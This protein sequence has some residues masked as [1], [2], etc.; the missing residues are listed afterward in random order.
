LLLFCIIY[1]FAVFLTLEIGSDLEEEFGGVNYFGD[2]QHSMLTLMDV[3]LLVEWPEIIRPIMRDRSF[4]LPF[5]LCFQMV[6]TFG[7]MNILIGVIVDSTTTARQ[8]LEKKNSMNRLLHA[9]D[10]WKEVIHKRGLSRDHIS[11]KSDE[12]KQAALEERKEAIVDIMDTILKEGLIDF[13]K[14]LTAKDIIALLDFDANS[15]IYVEEF[16]TGLERLL[17]GND[18]QL[19]CLM[20]T[21][22]G[23]MRAE[24]KDLINGVQKALTDVSDR[25]KRMEE[26]GLIC[27]VGEKHAAQLIYTRKIGGDE[28]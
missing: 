5:F 4:L 26:K 11:K 2:L 13:P 27:H 23:K 3:A 16:V 12:E 1:M 14:G 15:D 24:N 7:V 9:V 17:C 25:I 22:M 18:F 19:T 10:I 21:V 28:K 6:S 8:E 20:L